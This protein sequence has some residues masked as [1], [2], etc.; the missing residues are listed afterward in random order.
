MVGN[1]E[2]TGTDATSS[3]P[4]PTPTKK[5]NGIKNGFTPINK[6]KSGLSGASKN[7]KSP[8]ILFPIAMRIT[9]IYKCREVS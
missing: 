4:Q 2:G 8:N 3:S 5:A 9:S 6:S 1:K 7:A